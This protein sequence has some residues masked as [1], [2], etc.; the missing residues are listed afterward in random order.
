MSNKFTE[1]AEKALN[2]AIPIA[3]G[4]G[5]TYVGTKHILL[6]LSREKTSLANTFLQKH[7]IDYKKIEG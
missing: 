2:N 1:K 3:Q 4:M 7:G 5:H 6:A